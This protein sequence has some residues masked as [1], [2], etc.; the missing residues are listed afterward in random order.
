MKVVTLCPCNSNKNFNVCCQPI[1]ELKNI[2]D[3]PEQL[4]RSRYSAY[5][6]KNSEYIYNSYAKSSREKQTLEDIRKWASQCK[7]L[8][9]EILT[10]SAIEDPICNDNLP[11]VEFSAYYLFEKKLC[12]LTEKSRFIKENNHWFYLDGEIT[13]D[14]EQPLPKRNDLCP[15]LSQKKF[16]RCCG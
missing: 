14:K 1:I 16:K 2:A 6:I 8:R 12:Q 10:T 9:L 3:S 7:W 15:C 5:S 11:T 13:V 4:M